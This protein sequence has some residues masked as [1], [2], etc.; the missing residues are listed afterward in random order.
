MGNAS[1]YAQNRGIYQQKSGLIPGFLFECLMF[2]ADQKEQV[3]PPSTLSF[4]EG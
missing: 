1:E 4:Q 2:K 3:I